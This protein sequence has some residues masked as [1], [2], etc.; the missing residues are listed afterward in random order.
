MPVVIETAFAVAMDGWKAW[1]VTGDRLM[2]ID[3]A[4]FVKLRPYDQSLINLIAHDPSD[5]TVRTP[6]KKCQSKRPSLTQHPGYKMLIRLRNA[7]A[8]DQALGC[9]A[10][11]GSSL[12][13]SPSARS[14]ISIVVSI[15]LHGAPD[16]A[17]L[18]SLPA[19]H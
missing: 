6:V 16:V 7:G 5:V 19:P 3:G 13:A 12:L 14:S 17:P 11:A 9:D 15:A 4:R 2:K 1:M 18:V 8:R 10:R